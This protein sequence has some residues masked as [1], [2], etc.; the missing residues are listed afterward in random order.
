ML[1]RLVR[2]GIG[3]RVRVCVRSSACASAGPSHEGLGV[4]AW[5]PNDMIRPAH[6]TLPTKVYIF[7]VTS[8]ERRR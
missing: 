8:E 2:L 1:S 5:R 6:L 3:L 7:V 4:D